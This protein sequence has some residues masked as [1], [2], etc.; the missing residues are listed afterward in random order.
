MA[1]PHSL[2]EDPAL[3]RNRF[4]H[5]PA[6]WLLLP[7]LLGAAIDTTVQPDIWILLGGA[8]L[9]LLGFCILNK[10]ETFSLIFIFVAGTLLGSAWHQAKLF[11]QTKIDFSKNHAE[12]S[13]LILQAS[14]QHNE[15]EWS[16]VGWITDKGILFRRQVSLSGKGPPPIHS[17]EYRI[18]GWASGLPECPQGFEAWAR[19][20]GCTLK[21]QGGKILGTLEPP[22]AFAQWC[23]CTQKRLE[24]WLRCLP[25]EDPDGGSLLAAT[26]LGRT[27]LLPAEAK[28]NFAATGTLHLFAISGLHI[29]GMAA[30]LLWLIKK[31]RLPEKPL[32]VLIL[33]LLWFY[34]EITG[35]SPSSLRAWIMALFIW[36]G[37]LSERRTPILQSLALAGTVTLL[38][39]PEAS[40]DP[41]FQLSYLAVLGIVC[42]GAP[43]AE[44]LTQPSQVEALTPKH[45]LPR[46]RRWLGKLKRLLIS[47]ACISVAATIAGTPL[48]LTYFQSAS[49]IG[50]LANL[51]LVPL[52]EI[53]L[54]LG[55]ASLSLFW[56]DG[57]LPLASWMNGC[58]ALTL[59]AMAWLVKLF[60][61]VPCLIFSAHLQSSIS[62][63]GCVALLVACFLLQ[64]ESKSVAKL[65][66]VPALIVISWITF[67][68]C[69]NQ[70]VY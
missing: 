9:C 67:L 42:A 29:A 62:G 43:A 21:L 60:T 57:L 20:Q 38:F 22:S 7:L 59:D 46:M 16:A 28:L 54:L 5:T 58:A 30:A 15:S 53:P 45:S 34:V 25:W 64:A 1:R 37:Q 40:N 39:Q 51:I 8:T 41:G 65:L 4:G 66:G 10:N 44:I 68:F 12:L 32:G 48:T 24:K 13:V 63:Q 56:W 19:S 2:D 6:L 14:T 47:G 18:E 17:G 23:Y 31:L 36:V 69:F 33:I 3:N 50:V 61:I 35:A 52:S 70:I 11:P 27:A 26:L 49:W 55:M